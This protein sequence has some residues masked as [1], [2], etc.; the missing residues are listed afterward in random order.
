MQ[1]SDSL[2]L[3]YKPAPDQLKFVQGF[4]NTLDLQ[5]GDDAFALPSGVAAWFV[6]HGRL[7]A[8]AIL[9]KEER[10]RAVNTREAL[11]KLLMVNYGYPVDQGAMEVLSAVGARAPLRFVDD[12][13][14]GLRP[15]P[16]GEDLDANLGELL[17]IVHDAML[18][19]TWRRL[20]VCARDSCRWAFYDNS[21]NRSGTWCSM[22]V[23]GNREKARGHR[24][25]MGQGLS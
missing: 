20:K 6:R 3:G 5:D 17:A 16:V 8:G 21:R 10:Q 23:C 14:G 11:R 25:R 7:P 24:E 18:I 4:I 1:G 19:G 13:E 2:V 9:S 15:E 12:G 22:E